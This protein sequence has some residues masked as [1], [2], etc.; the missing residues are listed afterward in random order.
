MVDRPILRFPD[1]VSSVRRTGA[2]RSPPPPRGPGRARQGR[3]FQPTFDGLA[4]ALATDDPE[5]VLRE[6]PAGIAPE[7][8]LVFITA[9]SV[10][11][12]ARAARHIGLEVFAEIEL[13][14]IEDFFTDCRILTVLSVKSLT[15]V[16]HLKAVFGANPA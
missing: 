8:A 1:P 12:F 11:N 3:R 9:G 10:Q 6:D 7:R 15:Y 5:F 4:D 13:E 16:S 2:P 14:E